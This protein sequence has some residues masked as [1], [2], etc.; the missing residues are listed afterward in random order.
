MHDRPWAPQNLLEAAQ[1]KMHIC[2]AQ[3]LPGPGLTMHA[4]SHASNAYGFMPCHES[5]LVES[6]WVQGGLG[7][8]TGGCGNPCQQ[9]TCRAFRDPGAAM[10]T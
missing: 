4:W 3:Q 5:G 10:H 6:A 8:A 7:K 1:K 9:V 2:I